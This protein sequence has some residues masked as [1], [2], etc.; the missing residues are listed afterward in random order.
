M[1][2]LEL[3]VAQDL[4]AGEMHETG[5]RLGSFWRGR[6]VHPSPTR[7]LVNS[8]DRAPISSVILSSAT[9]SS[10]EVCENVSSR[11]SSDGASTSA[12]P[13]MAIDAIDI[14]VAG[15]MTSSVSLVPGS[16]RG[17]V[18]VELQRCPWD[19]SGWIVGE[20]DRGSGVWSQ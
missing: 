18:D 12:V 17:T 9:R 6:R 15:L 10:T 7:S 3:V 14:S 11:G 19:S 20:R 4:A 2:L 1:L 16:T 8:S 5:R 13:P